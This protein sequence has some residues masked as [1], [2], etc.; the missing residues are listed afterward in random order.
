MAHTLP[1]FHA[2][3]LVRKPLGEVL[4]VRMLEIVS[5]SMVLLSFLFFDFSG[6]PFCLPLHFT[7]A[8]AQDSTASSAML[9]PGLP[10][11]QDYKAVQRRTSVA[12]ESFLDDID[13]G[14]TSPGAP[15]LAQSPLEQAAL[16][17]AIGLVTHACGIAL[18]QVDLDTPPVEL[19]IG[20]L[21][22]WYR[23][24]PLVLTN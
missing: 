13:L 7:G 18:D 20:S 14:F 9:G 10:E 3:P 21:Q 24:Q 4:G 19:G 8:E 22:V 5:A 6:P 1:R 12:E 2:R 16:S 15:A 17:N 23:G 11:E